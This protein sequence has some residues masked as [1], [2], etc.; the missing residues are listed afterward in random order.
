M[1]ILYINREREIERNKSSIL[2]KQ[3]I[4]VFVE[5]KNKTFIMQTAVERKSRRVWCRVGN[6][7]KL[8][9]C[10]VALCCAYN[11]AHLQYI[12]LYF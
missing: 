2:K 12:Q 9:D 1:Y 4:S 10:V 11:D 8:G 3:E 6:G 5:H 7:E